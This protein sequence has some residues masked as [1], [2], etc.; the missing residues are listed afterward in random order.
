MKVKY[1][2]F[3]I[4]IM[5][6]LLLT[7]C[8]AKTPVN[9][10]TNSLAQQTSAAAVSSSSAT[11]SSTAASTTTA[12]SNSTTAEKTFTAAQLSEFNGQNGKAAYVAVHGIVYDLSSVPQWRGG[13]HKGFSAGKDLTTEFDTASPHN[14]SQFDGVPIVGKYI[15]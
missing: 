4:L 1:F 8:G 10:T 5:T 12:A 11:A 9:D 2:S 7:G 3:F 6:G 13:Q 15:G 14:I